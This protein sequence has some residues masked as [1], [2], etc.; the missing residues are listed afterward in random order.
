MFNL[1][2][3][4]SHAVIEGNKSRAHFMQ[5]Q[6]LLVKCRCRHCNGHLEFEI[7]HKGETISCPHCGLETVLFVP[8]TVSK[9]ARQHRRLLLRLTVICA[10]VF[11]GVSP[12]IWYVV[13]FGLPFTSKEAVGLIGQIILLALGS[14]CVG[15]AIF[16]AY[17]WILFPYLVLRELEKANATLKEIERNTK[18]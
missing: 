3:H 11:L 4:C 9:P 2:L 16:L 5:A 17:H 18:R 14:A 6:G 1:R 12:F 7:E 15:I 13:Q 10:L 8:G